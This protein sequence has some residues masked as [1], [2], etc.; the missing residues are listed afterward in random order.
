MRLVPREDHVLCTLRLGDLRDLG[1]TVAR[2]R[3]LFDLDA[4]PY[5]I[6]EVLGADPALAASIAADPGTRVPGTV[7]AGETLLRTVLG[8]QVSVAAAR[9]AARRLVL[10]L[11]EP[12]PAPDGGLSRLFPTPSVLAERAGEVLTGPTR[13]IETFRR[14]AGALAD[15]SLDPHSALPHEE[16]AARLTALPGIGR[17]T[18][19]YLA[20]RAL[21]A[22]DVLLTGDLAM[23]TGARA[24]G[25]PEDTAGLT[26]RGVAWA[27][28]RSYAGMHLWAAATR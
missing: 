13:R 25:L 14:V 15:G 9:T 3:R 2:A 18:S 16:L 21:K 20:I 27:P 26:A 8:Q 24:L 17:W 12:A 23:R 11:G 22:P 5:A 10:A 4:D 28:W 1:S 6:D 7:D 19:D